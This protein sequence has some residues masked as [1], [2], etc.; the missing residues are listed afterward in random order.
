VIA[1]PP[2]QFVRRRGA[3]LRR[4]LLAHHWNIWV[5]PAGGFVLPGPDGE[6]C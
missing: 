4:H 5:V 2:Q 6:S 3:N 1:E